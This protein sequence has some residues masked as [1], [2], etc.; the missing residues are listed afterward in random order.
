MIAHGCGLY[1]MLFYLTSILEL[2]TL[3]RDMNALRNWI[4][5]SQDAQLD[6]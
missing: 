5:L 2:N 6:K 4:G 1:Y 3:T